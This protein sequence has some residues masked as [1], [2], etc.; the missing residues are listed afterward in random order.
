MS[1]QKRQSCE[2]DGLLHLCMVS[3][4]DTAVYFCDREKMESGVS[5]IFRRSINVTAIRKW[6]SHLRA[7][8]DDKFISLSQTKTFS[9]YI[10]L[11][12]ICIYLAIRCWLQVRIQERLIHNQHPQ[13]ASQN[14]SSL[15]HVANPGVKEKR[16]AAVHSTSQT[17]IHVIFA[18]FWEV[19]GKV[20][21]WR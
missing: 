21:V 5:W 17:E 15:Q 6:R 2:Q 18:L 8:A 3:V 16:G 4:Y 19:R 7:S 9:F 20:F 14:D 11:Q 12:N 1:E 13:V 10:K